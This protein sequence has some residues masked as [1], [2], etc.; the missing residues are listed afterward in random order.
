[1][2]GIEC[3]MMYYT[4]LFVEIPLYVTFP[5]PTQKRGKNEIMNSSAH[6]VENL[7]WSVSMAARRVRT[8]FCAERASIA[9][10]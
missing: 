1:M 2:I 8:T 9:R 4:P 7:T 6:P 10:G 5:Q 3:N